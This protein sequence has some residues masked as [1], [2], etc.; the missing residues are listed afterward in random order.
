MKHE[1]NSEYFVEVN[2]SGRRVRSVY[3]LNIACTEFFYVSTLSKGLRSEDY[4]NIKESDYSP[5]LAS[6]AK[7]IVEYLNGYAISGR[8]T[9]IRAIFSFLSFQAKRDD[10]VIG[11]REGIEEWCIEMKRLVFSKGMME[12]TAKGVL[13]HVNHFLIFMGKLNRPIIFT[14]SNATKAADSN[15]VYTTVEFNTVI[16]LLHV[17]YEV[18]ERALK[19]YCERI[20]KGL[21]GVAC[22]WPK[23][24]ANSFQEIE[25]KVNGKTYTYDA[26]ISNPIR[27]LNLI[28]LYLFTYYT[29]APM[30]QSMNLAISDLITQESGQIVTDY[31]FKGRAFKFVRFGIGNSEVEADLVGVKWFNRFLNIR[32]RYLECLESFGLKCSEDALFHSMEEYQ[33]DKKF[34][35][36]VTNYD[37]MYSTN[38]WWK[39]YEDGYDIPRFNIR[40]IRKMTLQLIDLKGNDPIVTTSK[41]QHEWK[42]YQKNYSRGNRADN[43]RKMS[44]A[45]KILVEGGVADLSFSERQKL[46]SDHKFNLVSDT[47]TNYTSTA[48]GLGC[49]QNGPRTPQEESFFREQQRQGRKPKV[50]ANILECIDCSKCGIIDSEDNYYEILSFREAIRLNKATYTGSDIAKENYERIVNKLDERLALADQIKLLKAKKRLNKIGVSDVWKITI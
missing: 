33:G 38:L 50:C 37:A 48:T 47:D 6:L 31:Q 16:Y 40:A 3:D 23:S 2:N 22:L 24:L 12:M 32:Q 4:H 7:K 21:R 17:A 15:M 18:Y 49:K 28:S 36:L 29:A 1:Y 42:T 45:L 9:I 44:S 5:Q 11:E 19:E 26:I 10:L 25:V 34:I 27:N 46:A 20:E 39:L 30:S 8:I 35:P 43:L 13:G 14:F 41:A